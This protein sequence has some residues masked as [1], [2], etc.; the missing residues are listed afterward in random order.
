MK[1][2]ILALFTLST[3]TGLQGKECVT[4]SVKYL[5]C[6]EENEGCYRDYQGLYLGSFVGLNATPKRKPGF[7]GGLCMGYKS[8]NCFRAEGEFAYRANENEELYSIIS[9]VYS[10][11]NFG[12]KWTP[13]VGVGLGYGILCKTHSSHHSSSIHR[14][15]DIAWQIIAGTSLQIF[16]GTDAS[17]E[18]RCMFFKQNLRSNSIL[19]S[20][21]RYVL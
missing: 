17:F 19:I 8:T 16:E 2:F 13:Y 3:F 18:Y 6:C 21:K 9:N 12:A 1:K 11:F 20:L 14:D 5:G 10:D 15:G 7:L 4:Q